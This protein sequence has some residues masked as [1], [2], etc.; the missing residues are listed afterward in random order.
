[1]SAEAAVTRLRAL[2]FR[3]AGARIV[4]SR[5]DCVH[6]R[7]PQPVPIGFVAAV[8]ESCPTEKQYYIDG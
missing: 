6:I 4:R 3:I 8:A 7:S 1:M 5:A 2:S